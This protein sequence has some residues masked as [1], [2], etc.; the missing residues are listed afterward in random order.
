MCQCLWDVLMGKIRPVPCPCGAH[1]PA[2]TK[3]VS[4]D[5]GRSYQL[6]LYS[7]PGTFP[8]LLLP[9]SPCGL[10]LDPHSLLFP[11]SLLQSQLQG[12]CLLHSVRPC[13]SPARSFGGS[14]S[15]RKKPVSF[16][17]F[18]GSYSV[19]P[20]YLPALLFHHLLPCCPGPSHLV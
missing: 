12:L 20:Y 19:C 14:S 8:L 6:D 11:G 3:V 18:T 5:F 17:W 7:E 4:S 13:L 16:P 1:T 2:I 10:L 15:L 9:P